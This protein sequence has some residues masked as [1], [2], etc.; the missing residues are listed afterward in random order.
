MIGPPSRGGYTTLP[1]GEN[2]RLFNQLTAE[3]FRLYVGLRVEA[4][5]GEPAERLDPFG[6]PFVVDVGEVLF[7]IKGTARRY[8]MS[9]SAVRRAVDRF[10][11][12]RLVERRFAVAYRPPA[13]GLGPGI[14]PGT[15]PASEN[16]TPSGREA[17]TPP[18]VLRFLTDREICW[19]S[20]ESGTPPTTL[21]GTPP[22][23]PPERQAGTIQETKKQ[24]K[25]EKERPTAAAS[26]SQNAPSRRRYAACL[27]SFKDRAEQALQ[28]LLAWPAES[29]TS[30]ED[31]E[32]LAKCFDTYGWRF[33]EKILDQAKQHDEQRRLMPN[34]KIRSLQWFALR[35]EDV[36]RDFE[37][38]DS[39]DFEAE[40][41]E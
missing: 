11:D 25:K 12:L 14:P 32:F 6:R 27:F 9:T 8:R 4:Q 39:G 13:G 31:M 21:P 16:G 41:S 15:P 5:Y 36:V 26:T 35:A 7:S 19:V 22:G 3:Q 20:K 29:D 18:T 23:T 10:V 2:E 38:E 28:R 1:N 37:A 17:A 40:D 24:E 33:E 34:E 30:Y